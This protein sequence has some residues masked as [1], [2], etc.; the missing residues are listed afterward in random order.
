MS[1]EKRKTPILRDFIT[2]GERISARMPYTDSRFL[3]RVPCVSGY[4]PGDQRLKSMLSYGKE[5]F[6]GHE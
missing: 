3:G 2:Y 4:L 5:P 1:L 6:Y